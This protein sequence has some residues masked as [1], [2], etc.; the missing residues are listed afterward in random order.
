MT[1]RA[2]KVLLAPS[3][4]PF[5]GTTPPLGCFKWLTLACLSLC[6]LLGMAGEKKALLVASP[7]YPESRFLFQP[8]AGPINDV[9]ILEQLLVTRYG[10]HKDNI[11]VLGRPKGL[12][13][14]KKSIL[15]RLEELV[16]D[17]RPGDALLFSFHGHG[18]QQ[19][20]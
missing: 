7:I 8:L 19:L 12:R 11:T 18:F 2:L 6:P 3:A 20:N 1:S 14:T 13:A 15:H 16:R 17:A 5:A 10:F 4:V 9:A